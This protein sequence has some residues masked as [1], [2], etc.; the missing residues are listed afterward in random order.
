[1]PLY[2][3]SDYDLNSISVPLTGVAA[4]APVTSANVISD[5]LLG[6]P[7]ITLP[8]AYRSLGLYKEDGGPQDSRDD[9]DAIELFQTGYKMS[10]DSTLTVQI[11]LAE[12]NE[13][14]NALLDGKTPDENGVVYVDAELPSNTFLLFVATRNKNGT[15]LRRNGVA[16]IQSIETDQEERG[17]IRGKSVTFEWVPDALF[18]M[19]PYKKWFG[20]PGTITIQVA[21]SPAEVAVNGTV[22]L[23]AVTDPAG[24]KVTWTSDNDTI[25]TVGQDGTV[26]GIAEGTANITASV[27]S[28]KTT[29]VVT[30]TA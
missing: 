21:P 16:R 13:A 14:V 2:N 19:S 26:T 10:G 22:R 17:S 28:A 15:E 23:S 12:D 24:L 5:E 18:N 30:V 20:T 8:S 6:S 3:S 9:D 29:V 11:N 27:G 25:A 1:M 4:Y 7:T